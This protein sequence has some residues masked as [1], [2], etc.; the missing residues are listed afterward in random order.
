M[1]KIFNQACAYTWYGLAGDAPDNTLRS[2]NI[3]SFST[4]ILNQPLRHCELVPLVIKGRTIGKSPPGRPR[5]GTLDRVKDGGP[6]VAVK[7]RAL[8]WNYKE[9]LAFGKNTHTHL[10]PCLRKRRGLVDL[11][12]LIAS[13]TH[14]IYP[15]LKIQL[16][17]LAARHLEH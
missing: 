7:R 4:L 2:N 17:L 9:G 13:F 10:W 5:V 11:L 14:Q 12:M 16:C 1:C 8:N 3:I 6:F 15:S